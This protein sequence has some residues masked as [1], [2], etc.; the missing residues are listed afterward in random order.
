MKMIMAV[1]QPDK[2]TDVKQA[3]YEA[4]VFKMTALNVIGCGQQMGFSE[5]YR[6]AKTEVNLLKKVEIQVAVNEEYV[7]VTIDAI[8]KGAR[9]GKIGDGKI[10]VL[11]L[12]QCVRIRT[13]ET[14][15]DAIG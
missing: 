6:G 14:G 7:Q 8:I 15:N 10:F 9:T 1:I 5:S 13:G 3:L 4:K 12:P 11:D 2:L